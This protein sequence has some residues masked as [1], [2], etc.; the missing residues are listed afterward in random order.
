MK[1][2]EKT[3]SKEQALSTPLL[4]F[5]PRKRGDIESKLLLNGYSLAGVDEVGRGC[6]AGPVFGGACVLDYT[7]LKKLR[8]VDRDSLR[9]SKKMTRCMRQRMLDV[10]ESI[11][12]DIHV[13][14]ATVEEIEALGIVPAS[15]RAM[16][17][18]LTQCKTPFSLLL[19]DGRFPLSYIDV[20]QISIIKG[21]D[22]CYSIAAASIVAKE[23]RD[24]YMSDMALYYPE[25]GFE[26]HV[27]YGTGHH[28]EMISRYGICPLHR[29]NFAPIR[30][31]L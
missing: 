20:P 4:D 27:G 12:Y 22:L 25:Y 31:H 1:K 10:I 21:D 2:Q 26:K 19:V 5:K 11:A 14:M 18:A 16:S 7:K 13:G 8:R 23:A 15:E 9:D 3:I 30:A 29:K 28:R 17:R 24:R 6:L